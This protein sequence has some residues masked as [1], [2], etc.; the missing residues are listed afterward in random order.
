MY[1][2]RSV[3]PQDTASAY[4]IDGRPPCDVYEPR[5]EQDAIEIVCASRGQHALVPWGGGCAM[6]QG[7]PL[8]AQRW[9]ALCSNGFDQLVEFSPDDMVVTA[10]AGMTLSNLQS[11]LAGHNQ[12]LP[13]D[14]PDADR[15][16]LGG[17]VATNAQGLWRP[18]FG[19]PRDRLLGVRVVMADGSVV[20]GGG[21]VVKNVAGYDLCKLFAGS[22]GTLGFITEVTFKTNPLPES[23]VH[24]NYTAESLQAAAQAALKIH[25]ELLQP[26]YLSAANLRGMSLSVGLIGSAQTVEWQRAEI[27]RILSESGLK[28]GPDDPSE[29]SLRHW[30]R[31][32]NPVAT[33]RISIP[34]SEVAAFCRHIAH[35]MPEST[36]IAH[37]PVGIIE[38]GLSSQAIDTALGSTSMIPVGGGFVWTAIPREWRQRI[39]DVWGAQRSG[40]AI[41]R[42]IKQALDPTNLF[43][44][45][46]FVGGL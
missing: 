11:I 40:F 35:Q 43:S 2:S 4:S 33:A 13:I 23:R 28:P 44:P 6:G 14:A 41:M 19:A 20:R 7:N 45:G 27:E 31:E 1:D 21:K 25:T 8:R 3:I 5:N 39:G 37:I 36:I 16:T 9:A 46:R 12:F 18:A 32:L 38:I 30:Q 34:P 24:V 26:A 17:I 15:A 42:G 10:G 22:W 29:D